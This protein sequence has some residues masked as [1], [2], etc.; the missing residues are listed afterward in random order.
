MVICAVIMK[1]NTHVQLCVHHSTDTKTFEIQAKKIWI[2]VSPGFMC[3]CIVL[4]LLIII[5]TI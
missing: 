2:V 3:Q 1:H 5:M 4:R